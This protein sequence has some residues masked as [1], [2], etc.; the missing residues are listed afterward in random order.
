MYQERCATAGYGFRRPGGIHAADGC[1]HGIRWQPKFAD[2]AVTVTSLDVDQLIRTLLGTGPAD[3]RVAEFAQHAEPEQTAVGSYLSDAYPGDVEFWLLGASEAATGRLSEAFRQ[4]A[5]GAEGGPARF[6]IANLADPASVS[7]T[8]GLL[9]EA[10]C[11]LVVA[12]A[13]TVPLTDAAWRVI[14]RLLV[15]G[16]L[17][18]VRN[19]SAVD[20]PAEAGWTRLAAVDG[21]RK[22]AALWAAPAVLFNDT[23]AEPRGP[24]WVV[25]GGTG[26]ADM[27]AWWMVPSAGRVAMESLDTEW[28]WSA[29]ARE[30]MRGLSAVDFFCDGPGDSDPDGDPLTEL[31]AARCLAF[32]CALTAAREGA[33]EPCRVTVVTRR[34]IFDVA[35]PRPAT[36]WSAVRALS[37]EVDASI[38]LRLADVGEPTDLTALCWLA[39]HDVR[40]RELAVRDGRLYAPRLVTPSVESAATALAG[41]AA[42][43]R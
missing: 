4:G 26:L 27:W 15:P 31:A 23:A 37:H 22:R 9:R 12:D 34:A 43:G 25:A 14:R 7:F 33:D 30:E 10:A 39:R 2:P 8:G 24:R 11:D 5:L 20:A 35:S 41:F 28:L 40:E 3:V 19:A 16:G 6:A 18:L 21:C 29:Q 17:A 13:R 38:D 1:R 32:V 42:T 36:L